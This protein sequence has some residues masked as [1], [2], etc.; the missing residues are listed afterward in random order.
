MKRQQGDTITLIQQSDFILSQTN[1]KKILTQI[2]CFNCYSY[3]H[4]RNN[5]NYAQTVE[6]KKTVTDRQVKSRRNQT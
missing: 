1:A 4:R 6:Q 5:I 2:K 3:A